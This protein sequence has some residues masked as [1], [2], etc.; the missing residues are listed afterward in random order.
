MT[1]V[2]LVAVA[3]AAPA[4][5]AK[6]E[7]AVQTTDRNSV[8]DEKQA[9]SKLQRE[10]QDE[11]EASDDDDETDYSDDELIPEILAV[12]ALYTKPIF[13]SILE[14]PATLLRDI[15]RSRV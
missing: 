10:N 7:Q 13:N 11:E 2:L 6:D 8:Q 5:D 3:Y 4:T 15:G 14:L 9:D 1:L 12:F